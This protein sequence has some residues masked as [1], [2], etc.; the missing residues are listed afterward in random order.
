MTSAHTNDEG[1]RLGLFYPSTTGLHVVSRTVAERNP[2]AFDPDVQIRLAQAC[3]EVGLD[4]LFVA[5]R[6]AS[7]GERCTANG[8]QDPMWYAPILTGALAAAT[9]K[10]AIVTTAHTTYHEPGNIAAMGASIDQLSGGRW[11]I[12]IVTGFSPNEA[13]LFGMGQIEHDRR[14][15]MADDYLGAMKHLWSGDLTGYQ[16]QFYNVPPGVG[17]PRPLQREP[18]VISAGASPAGQAFAAKHADWMF[19]SAADSKEMTDKIENVNNMA[20][21]FGRPKGSIRV[22]LHASLIVRESDDEAEAAAEEIKSQVDLEGA[23]EFVSELMGGM[24]T[25]RQNFGSLEE[26]ERLLRVGSRGA[27]RPLFGSPRTVVEKIVEMHRDFNCRGIA[28]SLP[29]WSPEILRSHMS[30][31]L[32]LLAETG[33]WR[34]PF[35]RGWTW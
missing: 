9:R 5:D 23:R 16:G 35:D 12:N 34:S 33:I 22:M 18:L 29:L 20:A 10:I 24:D 25:M 13:G 17:S 1:L 31:I 21:G 11:G 28:F 6:W 8:F 32:P 15:E 14:Y 7:Y 27:A 2:D 19:M 4:Y 26:R 30:D 3:E